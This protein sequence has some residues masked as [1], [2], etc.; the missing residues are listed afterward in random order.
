[1]SIV[2]FPKSL[3][4]AMLVGVML[5]GALGVVAPEVRH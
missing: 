5:V 2:D 4:Q 3:S 1:M